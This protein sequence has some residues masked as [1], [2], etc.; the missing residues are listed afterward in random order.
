MRTIRCKILWLMFSA[1]LL[2]CPNLLIAEGFIA[3]TLVSTPTGFRAIE[4]LKP[5]DAVIS[6]TL[7]GNQ[8]TEHITKVTHVQTKNIVE[9]LAGQQRYFV[10]ND[11]KF[12]LEDTYRSRQ[13]HALCCGDIL[14][15][16]HGQKACI[17]EIYFWNEEAPVQ[18]YALSTTRYHNFCVGP[19]ELITHNMPECSLIAQQGALVFAAG[20]GLI[21][22]SPAV[23]A[24]GGAS[25]LALGINLLRE[26]IRKRNTHSSTN[27]TKKNKNYKKE[28]SSRPPQDPKK[29]NNSDKDKTAKLAKKMG[30]KKSNYRSH[31]QTVFQRGNR[32]ITRDVDSH[33]GGFWKMADSVEN[34]ARKQTRLGTY[35]QFLNRIGD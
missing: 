8:T 30:F 16:A 13:A 29:D 15:G 9:L 22:S 14:V 3:G 17:E 34:L 4:T 5:G 25:L 11:Q 35:D 20:G 2:I 33:N 32:F 7:L 23:V 31:G 28:S 12:Y 18:L 1:L 27:V 26:R 10:D 24:I 21:L 19:S 6:R